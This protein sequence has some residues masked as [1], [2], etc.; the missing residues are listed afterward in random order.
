MRKIPDT[1]LSK[2]IEEMK[3]KEE[4]KFEAKISF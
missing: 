4:W 2:F 3:N 1:L